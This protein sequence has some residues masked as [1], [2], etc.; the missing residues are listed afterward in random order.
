MQGRELADAVRDAAHKLEDTIQRV[1]GACEY[2]CCDSG[3]MVG[4]HGL[5]RITKGL[6]LNQQLAGR[7]RRGLQQRAVE[8][9]AD[10]ETI[11]RVADMLTTSYGEEYRAELRE[12]AELTEQWRQFAQFISSEFEFS[13]QNLDRLIAYSAI[14]H[15]LLRHLSVF[16]GSHSALV[17]LGG[18]DSS[19][20]FRGR[21]LAPPRCLF[22]VEGCLLG[23]YKPLHCANFFC[24]GEP[25]LL[26]ECQK[27]MDFD[28]FVL[29]NMRAESIE[30]VKSAIMLENELGHA[31]WEP[32]I[33]LISDE[34]HL[35]QLH[36]LV[37]QRPG[38]VER[39]HE[40]AGFYLSSEELLQ[41]IRAH[42]RTNT[43]VFTAPSV[44]GPALYELGIA[45]QQAHNDDILGGLILIADSFAVPS[46]APHPLWSDQMMSQ[47]LGG[48]DMYVVAPD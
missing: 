25:N 44:G 15:N 27:R 40:P 14:R 43:L 19:F 20:R 7:L 41:L 30:F 23:I 17:N 26:D 9:S 6:R 36:E 42:G 32:K 2:T 21:K 38:R 13:V 31:Y 37:R 29:A 39:R 46:F 10:L 5:R 35:E 18:P 16:P 22:H 33:V 28:E 4:S 24:S 47:P 48:L 8:V 3:T 1:C 45:L 11:E 34:R 12:L